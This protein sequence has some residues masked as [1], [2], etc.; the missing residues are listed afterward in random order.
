MS[1]L[2]SFLVGKAGLTAEEYEALAGGLR[3]RS[4]RKGEVLSRPGG[5]GGEIFFVEK[6]LLR[7]YTIGEDAKERILHFA[8][9]NWLVSDRGSAHFGSPAEYWID[10]IEASEVYC[11]DRGFFDRAAGLSGAFRAFN[12]R[13]LHGH[14]RQLERRI[15][16]LLGAAARERYLEFL[17]I[18][19]DL[20]RRAPLWMMASYMGMTPESLSRVRKALSRPAPGPRRRIS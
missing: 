18:Y 15:A 3:P 20:A 19:P 6:G 10:C 9:E 11:L 12:E 7:L 5:K 2:K 14:V 1:N 17:R 13:A 16:F 8:P 4:C